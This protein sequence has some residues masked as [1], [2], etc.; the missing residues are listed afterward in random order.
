VIDHIM[1]LKRG[2]ADNAENMQWQ[3]KA[4]AAAKGSVGIVQHWG[5]NKRDQRT[6]ADV[7]IEWFLVAVAVLMVVAQIAMVLQ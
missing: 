6:V 5:E 3:S 7:V 2:R 4:E 1:P